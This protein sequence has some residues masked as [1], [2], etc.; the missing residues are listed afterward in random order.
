MTP[1]RQNR[2]SHLEV[3]PDVRPGQEVQNLLRLGEERGYV[4]TEEIM[5]LA[6]EHDLSADEIEDLY[7]QIVE[8]DL[9]INQQ[10]PHD[11]H[12]LDPTD[13]VLNVSPSALTTDSLLLYF[14]AAADV[15][16]LKKEEEIELAKRVE[17]GDKHA[18]DRMIQS[19][20]RLVISIAK[21]YYTQD[22]DPLDLIQEG[23]TGLM[24][25]VEKFDYRRGYKFSTYATWWIRQA[26]TRAIA[27][28]DAY[29]R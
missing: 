24:R 1:P 23:N 29:T 3:Q 26:I 19:N 28:Q 11:A 8:L 6:E 22:L 9:E 16:L 5:T 2:P 21:K 17:T 13:T 10:A 25:A 15:P 12:M 18:K 4:T 14:R 20:L 27:N 7:S